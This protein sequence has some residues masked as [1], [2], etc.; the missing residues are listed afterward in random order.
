MPSIKQ[1]EMDVSTSSEDSSEMNRRMNKIQLKEHQVLNTSVP[2]AP[3]QGSAKQKEFVSKFRS[4]VN[5][6]I[7][8]RITPGSSMDLE[9]DLIGVD[10]A[11]A[12][13]IRRILI[14]EVPTMAIEK[15]YMYNNTSII[16]DEVLAHRLGLIPLRADPRKF[17][18]Y[19]AEQASGDNETEADDINKSSASFGNSKDSLEF[20]L[21]IRCSRR[22]EASK[23]ATEPDELYESHNVYTKHMKWLPRKDQ[24]QMLSDGKES[25][26]NPGPV[27]DDILIAKLRPGHELDIRMVAIKGVGKDHAKFSPVATAYYRL[28]PEIQLKHSIYGEAAERLQRCFSPG[29]IDLVEEKSEKGNFTRKR[30]VVKSARYDACS[31]NV[32]RHD[33]LKDAVNLN[34]IPD[35]F[36]FTVESTGALLPENLVV[37]AIDILADKCD[38]FISEL[39]RHLKKK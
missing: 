9:F 20:E 16:Q 33:D 14:S 22:Q 3:L 36:I 19:Q 12:N 35:H 25:T 34:K 1:E 18:W 31:R 7:V 2:P 24:I 38:T 15:V 30:A 28:L 6:I 37:Q 27:E 5:V 8:K 26:P 4:K 23:S 13:A 21:K 17:D 29:V 32:F 10:P 11:L 39:D